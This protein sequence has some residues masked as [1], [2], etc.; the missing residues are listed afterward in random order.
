MKWAP[1]TSCL[2]CPMVFIEYGDYTIVYCTYE[3][4]LDPIVVS[5]DINTVNIPKWCQLLDTQAL[6]EVINDEL[7]KIRK[8][9]KR[10]N[11]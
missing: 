10:K 6:I 9:R 4:Q 3:T 7:K 8:V 11:D 5:C 1:I 2:V